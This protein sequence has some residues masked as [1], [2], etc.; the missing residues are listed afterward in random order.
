MSNNSIKGTTKLGESIRNRRLELGLTIEKAASKA[1]VGTKSWYRYESGEAIR[2]DKA[3]GICKALN[4]H[5]FPGDE[6]DNELE[7]DIETYRKHTAWSTFLAE[8]FGEAAAI[9]FAIG[10]DL[11]SD[12]IEEDLSEL[13]A[14]PKGTHI[15][16]LPASM[17]KDILPEQFLMNYDYDFIYRLKL[18]VA[19]LRRVAAS[20]KEFAAHSVL[21]ELAIYLFMHE[22]SF[23]IE[24][25]RTEMEEAD[26]EGL[27]MIDEWAFELFDDS[28]I[29]LFLY[30]DIYLTEVDSYHFEHWDEDQFYMQ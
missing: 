3:K 5:V 9:S 27:D 15:G 1:G 21:E 12:H 6:L 23:L 17:L 16:Q 20:G 8:A 24:C 14:M 26:I 7:F 22:A 4:W 13:S 18:T 11:L 2:S 19:N 30:S 10:S 25:M 29:I 28:D